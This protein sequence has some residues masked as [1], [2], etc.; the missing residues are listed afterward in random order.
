MRYIYFNN[1]R[2][3]GKRGVGLGGSLKNFRLFVDASLESGSARDSCDTFADGALTSGAHFEVR[4]LEVWG[5]GGLSARR[6]QEEWKEERGESRRRA[7]RRAMLGNDGV[8]PA[9]RARGDAGGTAGSAGILERGKEESWILG[10][11][12][13][14]GSSSG[15]RQ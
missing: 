3:Q 13:L 11:L 14:F 8:D 4:T 9:E 10:L 15:H 6:A 7:V 12:G 1:K 2:A 5:C